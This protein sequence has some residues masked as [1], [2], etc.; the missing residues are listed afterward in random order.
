MPKVSKRQLVREAQKIFEENM[1]LKR[2]RQQTMQLLFGIAVQL[3]IEAP[4][5]EVFTNDNLKP[6]FMEQIKK[7]AENIKN[8]PPP[9]V[10]EGKPTQEDKRSHK[11]ASQ[12]DAPERGTTIEEES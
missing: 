7:A 10:L 1:I 3:Y 12:T 4:E 2:G 5:N 6:E 9:K 8:P 11:D